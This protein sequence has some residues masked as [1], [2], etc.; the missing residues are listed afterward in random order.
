MHVL[1]KLD[2][3]YNP[4][5]DAGMIDLSRAI[6]SG[7]LASLKKLVVPIPHE[8]NPGLKAACA[9]RGIELVEKYIDMQR[10]DA[11]DILF[12]SLLDTCC[13]IKDIPRLEKTLQKMKQFDV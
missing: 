8:K 1:E 7:S 2:L 4:I 13:R 12:N 10:E 11:D 3:S 6:S 5:G 9:K